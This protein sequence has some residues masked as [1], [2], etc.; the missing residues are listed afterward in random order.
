MNLKN[1]WIFFKNVIIEK[2]TIKETLE[3]S[4]KDQKANREGREMGRKYPFGKPSDILKHRIPKDLPK[5]RW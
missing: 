1:F 2:K 4:A 5:E 3:A